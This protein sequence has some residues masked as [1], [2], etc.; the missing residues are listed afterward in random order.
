MALE[1]TIFVVEDDPAVRDSLKAL[2]ESSGLTT[3]IFCSS[4]EFLR[5]FDPPRRGCVILDLE[6]P[7]V[8]GLE[9]LERLAANHTDVPVILV[10]GRTDV[11]TRARALRSGAVALLDKPLRAETLFDTIQRVLR[12]RLRLPR[13]HT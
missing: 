9:V 6:L 10:T 4:E 13:E 12:I 11:A 3:E 7:G 8:S 2:L 1:P 5:A